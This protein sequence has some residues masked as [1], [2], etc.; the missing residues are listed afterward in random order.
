MGEPVEY[1]S[2]AD[3]LV[4][5]GLRSKGEAWVVGG[6]VR[7]SLF[8]RP[9]TDMDIATT[10]LPDE[11]KELFP[12]S[13]MYGA[14]YGTVVVRLDGRDE[15]W[16]VTTLRSEGGY[17][18]GRRPDN[19]E[20]GVNISDDL[21][22]RDFTINA[23]AYDSDWNLIDPFGGMSDLGNGILKSVGDASKRLS[24]DGL[25]VMRAYRF[26]ASQK[27]KSMD[28]DLRLAVKDN[29]GMLAQVSKERIGQEMLRTLDSPNSSAA[30]SMMNEDGVIDEILPGLSARTNL[31]QSG[32]SVVN[33]A[34]MCSDDGRSGAELTDLLR[35]CLKMSTDDLREIS[36]LHES[37][38]VAIPSEISEIRVFR[39]ALPEIRQTRFIGYC[40]GLG[41]DMSKFEGS[42]SGLAPLRAG[43]SPIV[44]GNVLS[45]ATGL[46]PG[47]RMGRLKGLLH[48]IQVERDLTEKD[49]VLA[50][51]EEL[52]WRDSAHENWPALGWP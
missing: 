30:L 39:A 51:L 42:L 6:W 37:R 9:L 29:V 44:D 38:M 3:R 31:M 20:F 15:S 21:S 13:L 11:V 8:G 12:L 33:L 22:R 23:M 24:E 50:L 19:V 7:E 48:R 14:D 10:L 36:F 5:S 26:L 28:A 47:P 18:D 49:D 41:H 45:E 46:E 2:Q 52:D 27:V 43:N 1:A 32:D 35:G 4:L 17:G 34:L 25:R 16:E 40:E